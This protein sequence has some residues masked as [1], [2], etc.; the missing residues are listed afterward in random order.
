VVSQTRYQPDEPSASESVSVHS[1]PPS[2]PTP[3]LVDP[4]RPAS[5][6]TRESAYNHPA[7]QPSAEDDS[8]WSTLPQRKP[9]PRK[10]PKNSIT[11]SAKF[12]LPIRSDFHS[13][14]TVSHEERTEKRPR[15]TL[16][17]PPPRTVAIDLAGL[18]SRYSCVRDAIRKVRAFDDHDMGPPLR[19]QF[20]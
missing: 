12:R 16:Y 9:R 17:R 20:A 11:S 14:T 3:E 19:F 6:R 15:I 4:F 10:A 1:L 8:E 2:L 18:E 5:P 13:P 7:L